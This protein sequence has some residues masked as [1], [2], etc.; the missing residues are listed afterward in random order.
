MGPRQSIGGGRTGNEM[1]I[2][3]GVAPILPY[4]WSRERVDGAGL[5]EGGVLIN[6]RTLLWGSAPHVCVGLEFGV[7]YQGGGFTGE[8]VRY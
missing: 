5:D 3:R 4:A 6:T 2:Y 1:I 8:V 7:P